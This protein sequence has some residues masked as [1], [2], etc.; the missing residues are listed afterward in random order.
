MALRLRY[1]LP[2]AALLALGFGVARSA[3]AD[4]VPV[5][6]PLIYAGSLEEG[7]ALVDGSVPIGFALFDD[8]DPATPENRLCDVP[9]ANRAVERGRFRIDTSACR[10]ALA[11]NAEAFVELTVRGA[12]LPHIKVGAV[13]YAL[14]AD[15]AQRAVVAEAVAGGAIDAAAIADNAVRIGRTAGL[16]R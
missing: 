4:G 9:S 1:I 5:V 8:V 14:E 12:P 13:P 16:A 15:R 3:Q 2:G 10:A 11:D 7:G 6:E